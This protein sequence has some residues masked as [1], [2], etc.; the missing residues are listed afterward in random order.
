MVIPSLSSLLKMALVL[1][2]AVQGS[3]TAGS[4]IKNQAI[5]IANQAINLANL[6]VGRLSK[7]TMSSSGL[8]V[9]VGT[10]TSSL[11]E[12][13]QKVVLWEDFKVKS[14]ITRSVIV[15]VVGYSRAEL[16][17]KWEG[18]A[19]AR[20]CQYAYYGYKDN[21][22]NRIFDS[23]FVYFAAGCQETVSIPIVYDYL[24]IEVRTPKEG[25]VSASLVLGK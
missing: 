18:E 17:F 1:L 6:E 5:L 19:A 3:P 21:E 8:P 16:D 14:E 25:A 24:K 9:A 4:A 15:K 23:G 12:A 13:A 7:A 22:K 10:T 11:A 2:L 20:S